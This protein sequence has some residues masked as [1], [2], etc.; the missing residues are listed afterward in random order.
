MNEVHRP[1]LVR[2]C[3]QLPILAQL[4]LDPSFRRLVPQLQAHLAV[5]SVDPLG[6]DAPPFSTQQRMDTTTA[7]A[8]PGGGEP[9][10]ASM[11]QTRALINRVDRMSAFGGKA[12]MRRR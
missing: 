10:K 5:Q 9:F 3:G 4:C 11:Q 2:S 6:V 7:V 8:H 12:D 1:G